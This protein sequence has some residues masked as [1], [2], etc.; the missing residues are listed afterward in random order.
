MKI[1]FLGGTGIISYACCL[2]AYKSGFAVSILNRG[3]NEKGRK[4]PEGI[5]QFQAD[6]RDPQAVRKVLSGQHFDVVADFICFDKEQA[7]SEVTIFKELTEQYIFISS[8]SVYHKPVLSLPITESTAAY[9]PFWLYSQKKIACEQFFLAAYQE[10]GFPV[11]IIR[12]SHTYSAIYFPFPFGGADFTLPAR[13]LKGEEVIVHGDGE[14]LWTLTHA[15]DFASAFIGLCGNRQ[16]LGEIFHITSDEVLTW[17]Y[18]FSEIGHALQC[19]PKLVHI[20]SEVIAR[21]EPELGAGL[22][23]DKS[24]SLIFDN[25]KIKR[26]VPGFKACIPFFKGIRETVDWYL[27]DPQRQK[28]DPELNKK[29]DKILAIWKRLGI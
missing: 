5:F 11:T 16:A 6:I 18:I 27:Q 2:E 25:T 1:L 7:Q 19:R 24:F 4:L 26:F 29:I 28:V 13:M 15:T 3:R 22:L 17:N 9:N 14:T 21:L 12:P 23:G 20:P 10:Q 8:A